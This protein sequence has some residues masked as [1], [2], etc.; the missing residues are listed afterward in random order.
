MPL[1]GSLPLAAD[2]APNGRVEAARCSKLRARS[3]WRRAVPL[4]DAESAAKGRS[5]LLRRRDT[6]R[7]RF[8]HGRTG[9]GLNTQASLNSPSRGANESNPCSGVISP[10]CPAWARPDPGSHEDSAQLRS[11][12]KW[13][14]SPLTRVD[15]KIQLTDTCAHGLGT[16]A[17]AVASVER[18]RA[19]DRRAPANFTRLI[20]PLIRSASYQPRRGQN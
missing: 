16:G 12:P 13:A 18:T 14:N 19:T 10:G 17:D 2:A 20:T 9:F 1:H 8:H 6:G 4:F 3:S 15:A 5:I 7:H 11:Y